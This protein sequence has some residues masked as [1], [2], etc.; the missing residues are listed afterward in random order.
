[1]S[2][3]FISRKFTLCC[4]VQAI[5]FVFLWFGKVPVDMVQNLT[6]LIVSGY[7]IGNITQKTLVKTND[8]TS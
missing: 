1:M 8:T 6:G 4:A 5:L 3:K 2:D 7:I